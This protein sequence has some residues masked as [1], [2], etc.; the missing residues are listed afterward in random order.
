MTRR[1]EGGEDRWY[2]EESGPIVRP[3]TVT[4]GRTRPDTERPFT[5]MD[6]VRALDGSAASRAHGLVDHARA[7]LLEL[8][9]R[10][11]PLPLVELAADADLPVTVVRVVLGDLVD[12]GLARVDPPPAAAERPDA[13]LLREVI[14]GLRAL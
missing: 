7:S 13:D 4:G 8:L 11:G 1:A 10:Q 9:R 6:R 12:A 5:L 2:D 3:Y 14:R